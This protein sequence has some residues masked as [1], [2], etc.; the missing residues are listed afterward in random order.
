MVY[1][2]AVTVAASMLFTYHVSS[3]T[4][5]YVTQH[6]AA[7]WQEAKE[8]LLESPA[9]REFAGA[10]MPVTKAAPIEIGD[11]FLM[12]PMDGLKHCWLMQGGRSGE[13]FTAV[14]V[15]TEESGKAEPPW[16]EE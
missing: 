11:V 6:E 9:F 2:N 3:G 10:L 7:D 4:Q 15:R 1:V 8:T 5:S 13:Y 12:V 14:V 16:T